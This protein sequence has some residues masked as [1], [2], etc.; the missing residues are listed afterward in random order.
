LGIQSGTLE[1]M[2]SSSSDLLLIAISDP[3]LEEAARILTRRPQAPVVLHTSGRI[4]H[5]IL[6]PLAH[7]GCATGSLHPL[8]AF[9]R[10]LTDTEIARGLVFAIDGDERAMSLSRR[11]C[12]AL[13]ARPVPV[14]ASRRSLYHL[15][16]TLLAGGTV[17]LQALARDLSVKLGLDPTLTIG[18]LNLATEALAAAGD[19]PA[20]AITGPVARGDH[21]GYM[22]QLADLENVD[23]AQLPL[24]I[25]L[26]LTTLRILERRG[27]LTADQQLLRNRL[28]ARSGAPDFL[29]PLRISMLS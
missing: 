18:Y 6:Q 1:D 3:A 29:D 25:V 12:L 8:K 17:T 22:R 26:A 4:G 23:P 14:P 27:P 24:H 15:T 11:L 9:P 13:D 16:A 2:D 7:R 19:D 28:E 5:T 20:E 10:V 21:D